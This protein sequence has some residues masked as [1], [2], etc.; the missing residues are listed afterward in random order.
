MAKK[1]DTVELQLITVELGNGQRGIFV[2]TPL[3]ITECAHSRDE[4]N[5]IWF[6]NIQN[7]PKNITVEQLTSEVNEQIKNSIKTVH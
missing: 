7:I 5:G 6:S 4:I 2:G 1:T 3:V